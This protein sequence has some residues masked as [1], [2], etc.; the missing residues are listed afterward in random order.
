MNNAELRNK[1]TAT[2][3]KYSSTLTIY[4]IFNI[5]GKTFMVV[6]GPGKDINK[7]YNSSFYL[8]NTQNGIT[9]CVPDAPFNPKFEE[10]FAALKERLI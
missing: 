9:M 5:D 1:V 10:I 2:F 8:V 6:A 4:R 3:K 7:D